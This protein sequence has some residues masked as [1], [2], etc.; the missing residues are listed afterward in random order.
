MNIKTFYIIVFLVS[1]SFYAQ[2]KKIEITYERRS[3]K[4]ID[5]YYQ[6]NVPGSYYLKLEFSRLENCE[7]SRTYEQVLKYDSGSLFTLKPHDDSQG[8]SF[9][10]RLS[11]T[12]GNPKAK[13]NNGIIY[14]LPFKTE[15]SIKIFE[16]S[17][18]GEKYFERDRP[19]DWKS[20]VAY[21]KE[22]DTIYAMRKGIVVDVIDKHDNDT[23]FTKTFTSKRNRVLIE[24]EDGSYATYKGFN[25][26]EIFVKLGQKIYPRIP[27]G[28]LGE[29][30]KA[31]YRLDFNF[32]HY[33]K[34]TQDN[35]RS[36]KTKYLNP[37][38]FVDN[39][40]KRIKSKEVYTV[41]FNEDIKLQEFS[42]KE[43]KKYKKNPKD[44]K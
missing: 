4:S 5:F 26:G 34:D 17:N 1:Q 14:V 38:F 11:Y 22:S 12:R 30:N 3:D 15:K 23:K 24:H 35:N 33:I 43:K 10:Y 44:F 20:F 42:K 19:I 2:E 36:V 6:K 29:F 37:L 13:I 41:S 39:S 32:Y 40:N 28:K 27:L 8:I 31:N 25:R 7:N 16:A 21:S 9:S 18:I